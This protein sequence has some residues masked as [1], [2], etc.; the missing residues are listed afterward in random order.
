MLCIS[1][2]SKFYV[3]PAP[4]EPVPVVV[5][6]IE[7]TIPSWPL[8]DIPPVKEDVDGTEEAKVTVI[9]LLNCPP[10]MLSS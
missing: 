2:K 4:K 3:V 1:Y 9:G 8:I 5:Y 6:G 7:P 10:L